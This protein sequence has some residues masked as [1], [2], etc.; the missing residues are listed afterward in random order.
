MSTGRER[1]SETTQILELSHSPAAPRE[2]EW[3]NTAGEL[4]PLTPLDRTNIKSL[5]L[6]SARN[7][8]QTHFR[9]LAVNDL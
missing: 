7:Y 3:G 4:T 8:I 2:R 5:N 9:R 6:A 1:S